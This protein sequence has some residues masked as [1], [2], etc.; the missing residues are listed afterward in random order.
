M[1]TKLVKE[2]L[3]Q[4][5]TRGG[6]NKLAD[7]GVGKIGQIKQWLDNH[8]VINYKINDDFT[9]DTFT[10]VFLGN[11]L[12]ECEFPIFIQFRRSERSFFCQNNFMTSLRGCPSHVD[13]NFDCSHNNLRNLIGGP[14][15]N[16]GSSRSYMCSFNRLESLEGCPESVDNDFICRKNP[17]LHSSKFF[18]KYIGGGLYM[19]DTSLLYDDVKK[20]MGYKQTVI[21]GGVFV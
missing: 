4:T 13:G 10:A 3:G 12:E 7:I 5:F 8:N 17:N 21:K 15:Y 1:K 6:E 11:G 18:P 2:S 16:E 19:G 14:K 20:L 9:I